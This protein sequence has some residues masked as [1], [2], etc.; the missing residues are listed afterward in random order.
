MR[1]VYTALAWIIAGGVVVQAA[2]IAFAFGGVLNRVSN[3]DVVDK[4]LLESRTAGGVGESGFFI[5][6]IVGGV[7]LPLLAVALLIVSF[8]VRARGAKLW[9]AITLA[10]IALQVTLGFSLMDVPYHGLIHGANAAA[11]VVAAVIAAFRGRAARPIVETKAEPS[12]E[13]TSDAL[14]A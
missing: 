9:A 14:S 7:V 11:I 13:A 5:H 4:A 1:K 8:F 3:G 2:A 12:E 6:G 10:L